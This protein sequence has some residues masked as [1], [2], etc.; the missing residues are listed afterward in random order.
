MRLVTELYAIALYVYP[1][2]FRQRFGREM[3]QVFATR[4]QRTPRKTRFLSATLLDLVITATQERFASMTF[5]RLG[6]ASTA[7]ALFFAASLTVVQAFVIPTAS[8]EPSLRT[9]DHLIVSTLPHTPQR[10]EMIVFRYPD[11]PEQTFIKRVIGIP[12]DRIHIVNKQ[13]FR[14][15]QLNEAHAHHADEYMDTYRDNF[16]GNPNVHVESGAQ[17]MLSKHVVNG[18][19]VVPT[20]TYFVMGDNRDRS[21]DS[22]FFGFVPQANIVGRP[23]FVYWSYDEEA[24]GT[25]WDRTPLVVR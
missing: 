14:N 16:P 19:V 11:D 7:L 2:E 17:E 13:V 9:G 5:A 8:M 18:E 4:Y 3:Q 15:G 21:L 10:D 20:G 24:N 6:Y 22:R 1:R 12:G 25:R 23:W